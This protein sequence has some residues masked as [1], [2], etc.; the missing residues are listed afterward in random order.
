MKKVSTIFATF[1]FL[2]IFFISCRSK[3]NNSNSSSPTKSTTPSWTCKNCGAH[4]YHNHET[5][6]NMKVCNSC[7]V[8]N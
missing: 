3:E 2:T 5:V 7:G 6:S 8:G 4:S 1:I